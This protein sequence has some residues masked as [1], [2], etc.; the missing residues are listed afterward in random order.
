[1]GVDRW[2]GSGGNV[3]QL[4]PVN[5]T[6]AP[7]CVATVAISF[8]VYFIFPQQVLGG[9]VV[10][11]TVQDSKQFIVVPI[12]PPPITRSLQA[13]DLIKDGGYRRL[14][15]GK[16]LVNIIDA[17]SN[18]RTRAN[19][20]MTDNKALK[21]HAESVLVREAQAEPIG[22]EDERQYDRYPAQGHQ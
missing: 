13:L 22:F 18:V 7:L 16:C 17:G 4:G 21:S 3:L 6:V 2:L 20:A 11:F 5:V 9:F 1:M 15:S 12:G 10:D 19:Q 14:L 8:K